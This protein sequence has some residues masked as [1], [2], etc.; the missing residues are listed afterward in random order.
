MS[1]DL[2][3]QMQEVLA[4][5]Q[6]RQVVLIP[7]LQAVQEKFGYLPEVAMEEIGRVAGVSSNV[8]YGVASFYAQF[9]FI[10]PGEHMIKICL[11]TACHVRGAAGLAKSLE[12]ELHIEP[13]KTTPDGKF[14]LEEVRC[15]GSCA[16]APVIVVDDQVYGNMTT[17]KTKEILD[18][19][20]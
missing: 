18:E 1:T 15:F 9:R 14:S 4:P 13:G 6:G 2:K 11:G 20:R 16:L 12:R 8:V 10:K 3:S 7:A 17:T 19:F 5:L